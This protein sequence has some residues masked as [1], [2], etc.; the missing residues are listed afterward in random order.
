MH[1]TTVRTHGGHHATITARHHTWHGDSP[2]H[3]GGTDTAATPE[4]L[5]LGALGACASITAKM[6][7]ERKG[8][9]LKDVIITLEMERKPREDAPFAHEISE[10]IE[11][12]GDLTTEQ[13]ARIQEIMSRCPVRRAVTNPLLFVEELLAAENPAG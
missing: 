8:W 6:Y 7:A 11:L 1:G 12:I 2:I 10:K 4:E 3:D 5:L 9:P 13:R